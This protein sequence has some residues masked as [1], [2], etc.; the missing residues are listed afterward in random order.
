MHYINKQTIF[1]IQI[2][3]LMWALDSHKHNNFN[4]TKLHINFKQASILQNTLK[5]Q[6]VSNVTT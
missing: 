4:L 3:N 1:I 6:W 5:N 2:S